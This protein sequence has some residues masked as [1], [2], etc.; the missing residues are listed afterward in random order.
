[1]HFLFNIALIDHWSCVIKV[2]SCQVCQI[3][4][5]FCFIYRIENQESPSLGIIA[6]GGYTQNG[7]NSS[8]EVLDPSSGIVLEKFVILIV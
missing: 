6:V 7:R 2:G 3:L 5:A 1:M 8:V 4:S